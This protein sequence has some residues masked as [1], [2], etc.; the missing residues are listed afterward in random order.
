MKK[1]IIVIVAALSLSACAGG[2]ANPKI[3][4]TDVAN[5]VIAATVQA[6]QF[7]PIAGPALTAIIQAAFPAGAPLAV[8]IQ[9][10]VEMI[11]AAQ[12]TKSV[13]PGGVQSRLVALPNG[14][15]ISLK[16]RVK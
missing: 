5:S 8:G 16:G 11:C 14:Q 13:A 1:F 15:V 2:Q 7:E 12:A 3:S 9:V 4:W 6:C 10:A